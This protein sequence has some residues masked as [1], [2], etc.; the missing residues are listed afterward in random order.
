MKCPWCNKRV[1][2]PEVAYINCENYGSSSFIFKHKCG[3]KFSIYCQR[4]VKVGM[5]SK[6]DDT[7]VC[8]WSEN[9]I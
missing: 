3:K 9:T 6:V 7:A 1:N 4:V 2:I 5:I 8:S